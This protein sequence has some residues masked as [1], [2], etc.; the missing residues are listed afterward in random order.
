MMKM[1]F[2]EVFEEIFL[3]CLSRYKKARRRKKEAIV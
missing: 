2:P 1:E 3:G